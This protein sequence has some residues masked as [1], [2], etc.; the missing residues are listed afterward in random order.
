LT[1][2]PIKLDPKVKATI[3]AIKKAHA[4]SGAP[5]TFLALLENSGQYFVQLQY[6]TQ[7]F[8]YV[9]RPDS[10]TVH[11]NWTIAGDSQRKSATVKLEKPCHA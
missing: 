5:G 3:N 6:G 2:T 9:E 4:K 8:R 7:K 11:C 1:T 10:L